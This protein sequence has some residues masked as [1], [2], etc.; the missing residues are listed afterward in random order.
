M[1]KRGTLLKAFLAVSLWK[2]R[3]MGAM[4]LQLDPA[5]A[6]SISHKIGHNT[7]KHGDLW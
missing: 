6:C 7:A 4:R 3:N 5:R 1:E 2:K